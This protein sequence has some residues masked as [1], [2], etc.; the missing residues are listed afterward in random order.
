MYAIGLHPTS[1]VRIKIRLSVMHGDDRVTLTGV[2]GAS[3]AAGSTF[4]LRYNL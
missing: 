3:R 4:R 1:Y 2:V